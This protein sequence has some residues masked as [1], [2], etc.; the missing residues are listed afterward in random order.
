VLIRVVLDED[1][2]CTV[3]GVLGLAELVMSFIYGLMRPST[4]TRRLASY[5]ENKECLESPL[6]GYVFFV[7]VIP[8]VFEEFGRLQEMQ[9]LNAPSEF[10]ISSLNTRLRQLFSG[11]KYFTAEK[12]HISPNEAKALPIEE[13]VDYMLIAAE[14]AASL[15]RKIDSVKPMGGGGGFKPLAVSDSTFKFTPSTSNIRPRL[16]SL[17]KPNGFGEMGRHSR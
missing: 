11:I 12:L 7:K 16:P 3:Y 13:V 6:F 1:E 14:E 9:A 5:L 10:S 8:I 17:G 15:K 2:E 4:F